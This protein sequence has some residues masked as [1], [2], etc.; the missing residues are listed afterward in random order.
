[1]PYAGTSVK[2]AI[3]R[4]MYEQTIDPAQNDF[5]P[6]ELS[7]LRSLARFLRQTESK[8]LHFHSPILQRTSDPGR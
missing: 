8:N 5:I 3:L 4:A 6:K 1:M 2:N 7:S